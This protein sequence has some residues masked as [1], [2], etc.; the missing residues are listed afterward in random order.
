MSDKKLNN[1]ISE[2]YDI[3][4]SYNFVKYINVV[5]EIHMS[6]YVI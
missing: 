4:M 5:E 2:I 3:K 6:Y 1:I